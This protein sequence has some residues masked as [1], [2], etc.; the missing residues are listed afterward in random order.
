MNRF[1]PNIV[2]DGVA[3]YAE[4]RIDELV[5]DEVRLKLVKPCTRCRITRTDQHSGELD[6]EEPLRTLR[7]YR[8]NT[9]LQGLLFGQNAVIAAGVG[10]TLRCGQSLEL[11]WK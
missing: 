1:R 4:D 2:I 11:R 7:G 5:A 8:H 9:L 10:A 3:A 6:G